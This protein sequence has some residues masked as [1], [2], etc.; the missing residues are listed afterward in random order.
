[1]SVSIR[2]L[3]SPKEYEEAEA[4]QAR[5][6]GSI[7]GRGITPKEIMIAMQ[8]NGGMVLGAFA[9]GRMVGVAIMMAGNIRGTPYLY[10]HQTGVIP[11]YQSA[12]VGYALKQ[13]QKQVASER[14]TEMIAWTFDPIIA[15]NAYFNVGK[16]GAIARNYHVDYYG[17][18]NDSINYGWPT[19]RFLAEWYVDPKVQTRVA[20]YAREGADATPV[21]RA[22]GG[23][24]YPRCLD[25]G[26]DL[27]VPAALIRIPGDIVE[28]KRKLPSE[29]IRWREATRE[30]FVAYFR[31]GY[32]AVS[33]ARRRGK[34]WYLLA[35]AR[36]PLNIFEE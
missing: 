4:V 22:A 5:A 15:R 36:L 3:V 11:E 30:L 20:S 1:M 26:V 31:A 6:W 19:D 17:Q 28:L 25:W 34:V 29:A 18:M 14:G 21:L 8:D 32:S 2:P 23:E 9:R 12:G 33:V 16:L 7:K 24:P 13:K 10:S 35:K 27:S